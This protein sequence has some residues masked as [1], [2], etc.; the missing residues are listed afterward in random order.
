MRV[1]KSFLIMFSLAIC[2]LTVLVIQPSA[3]ALSYSYNDGVWQY[4]IVSGPDTVKQGTTYL[5]NFT[6][7]QVGFALVGVTVRF[8]VN[9]G[10]ELPSIIMPNPFTVTNNTNVFVP[11]PVQVPADALNNTYLNVTIDAGN[12]HFSN[13]QISLVQNPTYQ[14]L[15]QQL[16]SLLN[17]QTNL[18]SQINNLQAQLTA[19]L[20]NNS[21][22]QNQLNALQINGSALQSQIASLQ[23]QVN[24]LQSTNGQLQSQVTSLQTTN[25]GL[26]SAN[27]DLQSQ[28]SN[29][30]SSN[31]VL[32]NQ[33]D[34]L[35]SSN[36][37][38]QTQI[39]WLQM[40]NTGL[41]TQL[42]TQVTQI[43]R[44]TSENSQLQSQLADDS[45]QIAALQTQVS[46]LQAD[47]GNAT[48]LMLLAALVAAIFVATTA[49]II[50]FMIRKSRIKRAYSV[51]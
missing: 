4:I 44:I 26:R 14:E 9:T 40:N 20:A 43:T 37:A 29:L 8:I 49:Y 31:A 27:N 47:N 38:L 46:Q 10:A 15:Q 2:L 19:A 42:N 35:N 45:S 12:Q 36:I 32:Q 48:T 16:I 17:Q 5:F 28:V 11:I 33:I 41:Q 39:N 30:N 25:D 13:L 7:K 23:A 51:T 6:M 24:N 21:A 3:Q 18:T 50:I 22:L 1:S 34:D